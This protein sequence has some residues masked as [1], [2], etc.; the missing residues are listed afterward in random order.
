MALA[1][2]LF[3]IAMLSIVL[4]SGLL[5]GGSDARATRNYRRTT[6]V[7]F[8]AESGILHAIQ[9]AN[10]S[11]GIGVINFQNDVF[12]SWGASFGTAAKNFSALPG[13]SYSVVALQ[14][15]TDPVNRGLFRATANGPE[16]A[17]N[18]VVANVLRS[19]IPSNAPGAVHLASNGLTNCTFNGNN[20]L[21]DGNDKN[22]TTGANGPGAAVPGISTR[23]DT[24]TTEATNSLNT[25]QKHDVTGL[26]YSSN[27]LIPSVK[28]SPGAPSPQQLD[29]IIADLLALPGVQNYTGNTVNNSSTLANWQCKNTDAAPTP[30][31]THFLDSVTFR[32]NGNISGQGI[33]IV[34]GDLNVQGTL[35]FKGLIIVRGRTNVVGETD[36][37]GNARLWGSLWTTDI[38]LVVGGSAFV[39]YSTEALA[40]AN[41]VSQNRA[42]PSPLT[43]QSFIDCAS[44]PANTN[45]C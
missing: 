31:I 34:D 29:N 8:V 11:N 10:V 13:F 12:N 44:V 23:N 24:N 9:V 42:L 2:A 38:N 40:L 18:V 7:H 19:D 5:I 4:A 14:N 16:G 20:F 30:A 21:I 22:Y 43:V 45:G 17:R 6:Q 37:T 36:V 15:A 39:Q 1:I 27:P 32:G 28:T 35:D 26:G 25:N 41:I 33:M 3:A